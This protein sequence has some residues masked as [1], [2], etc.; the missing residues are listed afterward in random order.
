MGLYG[1]YMNGV[2]ICMGDYWCW[3]NCANCHE[4]LMLSCKGLGGIVLIYLMSRCEC[5]WLWMYV[6][7]RYCYD[8][9]QYI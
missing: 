6:N 8:M 3:K 4:R 2:D 5:V 1:C 9:V 7:G